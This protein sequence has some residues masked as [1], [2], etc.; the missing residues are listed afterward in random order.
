MVNHHRAL[1]PEQEREKIEQM[2]GDALDEPPALDTP[3]RHVV[4][5]LDDEQ[6][7]RILGET[8]SL[9]EAV[10]L[11]ARHIAREGADEDDRDVPQLP[12]SGP[13]SRFEFESMV[14]L[15]ETSS[16]VVIS[17]EDVGYLGEISNEHPDLELVIG[18][19]AAPPIHD[20]AFGIYRASGAGTE[21]AS[22]RPVKPASDDV[23]LTVFTKSTGKKY[24]N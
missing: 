16:D 7:E 1:A 12:T 11:L 2:L 18:W 5:H 3:G 20:M 17:L 13:L 21:R 10:R 15:F 6:G 9:L 24:L 19:E 23:V 14:D 8:T 4:T 22:T